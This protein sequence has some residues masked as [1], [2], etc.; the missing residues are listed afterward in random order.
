MYRLSIVMGSVLLMISSIVLAVT[1]VVLDKA[2]IDITDSASLQRGAKLFMNYCVGC[3]SLKYVR[4][5]AM[6]QDIGIVDDQSQVLNKVLATNLVL[7]GA[8]NTDPILM[9]MPP[10]DAKNWFGIIPPDLSL[11]GR[12]RGA[13]WL[14]TYLRSFYPD[15]KKPWGVNNHVFP[16]VAMPHILS[17]LENRLS[18]PEFDASV[19][20]LVNFLMLMSEPKQRERERLGVWV[21]LFLGVFLVFTWLLKREYWKD[22]HLH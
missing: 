3:H 1:D 4:Y 17:N 16:D 18:K 13:D 8:K 14:Y 22:V 7:T 2:H 12:S 6:A 10:E 19:R 15:P 5:E 20:D 9:S 11:V 21:L